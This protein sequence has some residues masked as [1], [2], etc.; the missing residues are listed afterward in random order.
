MTLWNSTDLE[1]FLEPNDRF[2]LR[3]QVQSSLIPIQPI[4]TGVKASFYPLEDIRGILFDLYGT[5][6]ISAAGEISCAED[7]PD[8]GPAQSPK[9]DRTEAAAK[10]ILNTLPP[11]I[12]SGLPIDF[13][14]FSEIST[15]VTRQKSIIQ[16]TKP[17]IEYSEVDIVTLW[18]DIFAR[19]LEGDLSLSITPFMLA[20]FILEYELQTNPV[21]LMPGAL[22]LLYSLQSRNF[23][24][25]IISNAQFYTSIILESLL[26]ITHISQIGFNPSLCFWSYRQGV[27]KPEKSIFSSAV[28]SLRQYNL[29]PSQILYLGNDMLNDIWGAS[30][31]G[32]A[33]ALFVGDQRSLRLQK[34][35]PEVSTVHPNLFI[36]ELRQI[37]AFL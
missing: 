18:H 6:L 36:T 4:P 17:E 15:A 20:R 19:N 12:L 3:Q 7:L 13:D 14:L 1:N 9:P 2:R 5:L 32:F 22:E 8:E 37:K 23:I 35:I 29:L 24:M 25:G 26:D 11:T 16:K 30:R 34:N 33:T 21:Q 28:E 10:R 27:A 31:A